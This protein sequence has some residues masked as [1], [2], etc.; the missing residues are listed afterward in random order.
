MEEGLQDYFRALF[1]I[2]VFIYIAF[3]FILYLSTIKFLNIFSFFNKSEFEIIFTL[4]KSIQL[5]VHTYIY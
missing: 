5:K 4:I 1:I 3:S 2:I